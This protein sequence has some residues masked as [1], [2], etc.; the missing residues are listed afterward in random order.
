MKSAI[1]KLALIAS[2]VVAALTASACKHENG[3][4]SGV[5]LIENKMGHHE[6]SAALDFD[7]I[8][9][10]IMNGSNDSLHIP[11]DQVLQTVVIHPAFVDV[12]FESSEGNWTVDTA[13]LATYD[14]PR[15]TL[16][17]APGEKAEIYVISSL[18]THLDQTN[19][20]EFRI[21][22]RDASGITTISHVF[23]ESR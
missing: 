7:C 10:A 6:C 8:Q 11:T 12:E 19:T 23:E 18:P 13:E 4:R 17:I 15:Q 1:L 14:A 21:R 9:I 2:L 22:L 20:L 16:S 3:M 5:L